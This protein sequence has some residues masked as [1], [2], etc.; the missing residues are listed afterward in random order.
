MLKSNFLDSFLQEKISSHV[1]QLGTLEL[2]RSGAA[3]AS[4]IRPTC[5]PY[6][7]FEAQI[8]IC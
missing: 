2:I 8:Q 7:V 4:L 6:K 3:K 5:I 1:H